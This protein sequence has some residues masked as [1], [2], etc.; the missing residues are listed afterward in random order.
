MLENTDIG[1]EYTMYLRV[2]SNCPN[3]VEV[4]F[5]GE[6]GWFKTDVPSNSNDALIYVTD[7]WKGVSNTRFQTRKTCGSNSITIHQILLVKGKL[8][9]DL[10]DLWKEFVA[11]TGPVTLKLNM[12]YKT[13]Y[14]NN[15]LST[16][17]QNTDIGQVYTMK[18][19]VTSTCPNDVEIGFAGEGG[20]FKTVVPA[21]SNDALI[22][23]TD[24]WKGVANTRFQNRAKC[25]SKSITIHKIQLFNGPEVA[26]E[27]NGK[28]CLIVISRRKRIFIHNISIKELM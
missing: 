27:V 7:T 14:G 17:L 2:T 11:K 21:N 6:G 26:S 12:N 28:Y 1:K 3:D 15:D 16:L 5:S 8:S 24:S 20:W 9:E 23:V 19:R 13:F 4:G 22:V 18:L 10:S 25:G